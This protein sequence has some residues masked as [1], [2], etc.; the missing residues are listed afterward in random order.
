MIVLSLCINRLLPKKIEEIL[1]T[2]IGVNTCSV[3]AN[4]NDK[5]GRIGG[6]PYESNI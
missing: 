4:Q 3:K 6:N 5:N 1:L 2:Y